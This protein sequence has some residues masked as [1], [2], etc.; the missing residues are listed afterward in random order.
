MQRCFR[1]YD[2]KTPLLYSFIIYF[3]K[4]NLQKL[5]IFTFAPIIFRQFQGVMSS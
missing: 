5:K 4:L 2:I 1:G 3:Q